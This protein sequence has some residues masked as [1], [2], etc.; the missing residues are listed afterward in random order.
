VARPTLHPA[1]WAGAELQGRV[2]M[3]RAGQ[4]TAANDLGPEA[5]ADRAHEFTV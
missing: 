5:A 3:E 4:A 2:R 1:K